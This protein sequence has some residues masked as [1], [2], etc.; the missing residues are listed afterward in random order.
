MCVVGASNPPSRGTPTGSL[1]GSEPRI[2]KGFVIKLANCGALEFHVGQLRMIRA[3][4][5][6]RSGCSPRCIGVLAGIQRN[7]SP[8]PYDRATDILFGVETILSVLEVAIAVVVILLILMHSGKDAGLSGA[9]GVGS[10]A[11][12][13]GGGSLVERNLNRWTI[14][15]AVL[16]FLNALVLLKHPWS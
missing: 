6:S 14:F 7:P 13:L 3:W 5:G 4:L 10:G 2:R 9:F 12:P 15:F 16:F 1:I 8:A 11:G